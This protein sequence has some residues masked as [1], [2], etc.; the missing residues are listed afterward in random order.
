LLFVLA[1]IGSGL[2]SSPVHAA[3]AGLK[4]VDAGLTRAPY[5]SDLTASSVQVSWA[6]TTQSRGVVKYGPVGNCAAWSANSVTLSN[7]ITVNGVREY[8]STVAVTGLSAGTAY[9]YRVYTGGAA[10]VDLLGS[11]QTPRFTTLEA[12]GSNTPFTFDVFGDW[13]DTTNGGVNNGSL[14][15]NQ[16]ALDA[17]LAASGARFAISTGD[18]GYQ[19]GT[20]TNYGDLKQTGV[21][22]GGVFGPSYWAA[23]GQRLPLHGVSG[24]HGQSA[25]FLSVWPQ[26]ASSAASGGTYAMVSYPSIDGSRPGNYP[27]S[28][29]AFSTGGVRFYVLDAAWGNSN[30]GSATGGACGPHCSMYQVDHDAH[31]TANAAQ[32]RWLAQDLAAHP[33]GLKMAA[34][35]FPLRSDDATEPDNEYLKNTPGSTASLEKLLH[36]NGVGLVFNGHAHDYQRNIAPPGGVTSYVSGGGG[37]K[38]ASVGG[39]GCSTTDAYA[40]GWSYTT[41]KGNACGAA[42]A[43]TKD[44]QV[45][46]FLKV[47]VAGS[48]VTVTPTDSRGKTF[49]V[50]TYN[51]AADGVA[52]SAPGGLKAT[53]SATTAVL[54]WTAAT[55]NIGVSAYDIY[56][57]GTYLATTASTVTSYTDAA[58]LAGTTYTYQV[59]ARDLAG[60]VR[61]ATVSG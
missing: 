19:G 1:L 8:R 59:M 42:K 27:T 13:G 45:F 29:Y 43:P 46:H 6:T 57:N 35:H 24:N 30:V 38:L 17:R 5:L 32:Y 39:H 51:F 54:S 21:N 28:Y 52:P 3:Q 50:M 48:K 61:G 12:V 47:T 40:I 14:N 25:T 44:S 49:D 10:P 56:R 20:E 53:R 58:A 37:A 34:F 9:C 33:G 7:P 18:I 41:S 16:A 31:W 15:A 60:N 2:I 4:G 36:D 55:D 26:S 22:I 23:P 11:A